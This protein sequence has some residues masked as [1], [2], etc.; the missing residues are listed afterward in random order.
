MPA[1]VSFES[2]RDLFTPLPEVPAPRE[3]SALDHVVDYV[4]TTEGTWDFF[5]IVSQISETIELYASKAF[6]QTAAK[7]K[8][9]AGLAG[10][11]L[12]VPRAFSEI[13]N[14]RRHVADWIS[15]YN[16]PENDPFKGRRIAQAAKNSITDLFSSA[17]TGSQIA[18]FADGAKLVSLDA[19]TRQVTE[20]I[21]NIAG[22]I[23]DG[24]DLI[25]ECFKLHRYGSPEMSPRTPAETTK[26]QEKKTLA[27]INI[28]KNVASIAGGII[29]MTALVFG[30]VTSSVPIV[31]TV[32]LI[33]GSVW[34]TLKLTSYFYNKIVVEA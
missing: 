16:L 4:D 19:I 7:V 34:L 12:S 10:L 3:K 11:G 1:A 23:L 27:W 8:E 2:F 31:A 28:A 22:G 29:A 30:V 21:N 13:N 33:T 15:A 32:L 17:F 20:G 5:R 14:A 25:G 9:V 26:L 6:A 24:V 18:L